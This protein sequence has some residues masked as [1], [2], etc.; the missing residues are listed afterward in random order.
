MLRC[1]KHKGQTRDYVIKH[2]KGY[3]AWL[4]RARREKQDLPR[5]LQKFAENLAE[6]RGGILTVGIHKGKFFDEVLTRH[7][8]YCDWAGAGIIVTCACTCAF[9]HLPLSRMKQTHLQP[10]CPIPATA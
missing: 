2:D 9:L 4:L 8:D 7:A 10:S 5:D 1:G 3:C 6:Q